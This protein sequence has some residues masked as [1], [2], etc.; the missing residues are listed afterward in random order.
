MHRA[1]ALTQLARVE[2]LRGNF[3]EAERLLL[4]AEEDAG[5]N[6]AAWAR[7]HLEHGRLQR[8]R[9][10]AVAALS[11]FKAAFATALQVGE[12]FLAAD[13]AHMAALASADKNDHEG[14]LAW[15]Q[16]GIR[17]AQEFPDEHAE[18]WLGPLLNNLGWEYHRMGNHELA[19][20]AFQRALEARE[21]HPEQRFKIEIARYAV[22]KTLRL[23]GRPEEA[24]S[25]LEHAVAWTKIHGKPDGWFHE[26]L[27]EDYAAI[28]RQAD[29]RIQARLALPLLME[30]D[31]TF[32]EDADRAARL[33][34][35][36]GERPV[37][38]VPAGDASSR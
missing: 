16:R 5:S 26:E 3:G 22:G 32:Q 10:D 33:H 9:G 28:G 6:P 35:L 24:A 37:R 1:E 19:L 17:V 18:Y 30:A 14:M 7:I 36:A 12:E 2:G 27:A 34:Q 21:R 25:I 20:D 11:R 4:E 15:T 8:S 31:P 23:L 13:A 29:A 38:P